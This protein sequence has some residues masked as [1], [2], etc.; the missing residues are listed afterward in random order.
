MRSAYLR[1]HPA[2]AYL[3]FVR[4]IVSAPYIAS[5]IL[6]ASGAVIGSLPFIAGFRMLPRWIR[7]AQC[8]VGITFVTGG[9]LGFALYWAGSHISYHVH[10]LLFLHIVLLVGMGLGMA[11]LVLVSGEYFKALRALDAARRERL[12]AAER[13]SA[14]KNV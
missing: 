10:K 11:L 7:I 8:L 1:R 12:A 13:D 5:T 9:V 2:V 6:L 4:R 3:L 14:S